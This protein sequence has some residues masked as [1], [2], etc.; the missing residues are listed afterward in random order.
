MSLRP[1]LALLVATFALAA[2]STLEPPTSS[3]PPSVP[4]EPDGQL[5]SVRLVP[6]A[7]GFVEPVGVFGVP[8]GSGRLY[9]VGK[10]GIINL[11]RSDGT[12]QS[13]LFLDLTSRVGSNSSE[14]GLLGLA[15][16]P[17]FASNNRFFVIYTNHESDVVLSE[18][19][20]NPDHLTADSGF[21]RMILT[22]EQPATDHKGSTVVFGPDGYLYVS[23]GDGGGAY[24]EFGNGQ[25]PMSLLASVLRIDPTPFPYEIPNT[26][27]FVS[28]GGAP[29]KWLFGL[30]NPYRMSFD[31]TTGDLYIGDVG[32]GTAEEINRVPAGSEG[33]LNYGWPIMEGTECVRSGCNDAGLTLP[34][35]VY[36]HEVGCAIVGGHVYRGTRQPALNGTYVYGDYCS[37]RIWGIDVADPTA[38]QLLLLDSDLLIGSFGEH[39]N[40]ELYVTDL[41]A[42]TI[43]RLAAQTN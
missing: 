11:V 14:H 8:D 7:S 18:F 43:Y 5:Q 32:Q 17:G 40:G 39:E 42:G 34:F 23:L 20:A 16:H 28:G 26:N 22:I 36:G 24:D 15:F 27:P 10:A 13:E 4:P 31:R 2:C 33:G 25:D 12:V 19:R 38:P 21:E 3:L 41:A 6:V 35:A 1:L 37:G 9:V 29:E 30:R